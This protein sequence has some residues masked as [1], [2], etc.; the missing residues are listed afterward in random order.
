MKIGYKIALISTIGLLMANLV[1]AQEIPLLPSDKSVSQGQLPNGMKYF[2]VENPTVKGTADFALVNRTDNSV[3]RKSDIRISFSESVMDST[4][5]HLMN[6]ADEASPSDQA[7]I[8]SG[9]VKLASVAEKIKM[10]SY[11]TPVRDTAERAIY[12][13]KADDKIKVV[14]KENKERNLATIT[15]TWRSPRTDVKLMNTIQPAIS[16]LFTGQMGIIASDRLERCFRQAGIPATGISYR[17]TDSAMTPYDEQFSMTLSVAPEHLDQAVRI[18]S[19]VMASVDAGT[20]T[21]QEVKRAHTRF[22]ESI[23]A[24]SFRPIKSNREFVNR[25]ASAYL[26]NSSLASASQIH[27]FHASRQLPDDTELNLFNSI[28]SA[29]LDKTNN[30][31]IECVSSEAVDVNKVAE[32]FVAAWDRPSSMEWKDRVETEAFLKAANPEKKMKM[33]ASK[34]DPMSSGSVFTL[35]NGL[36]VLCR[37]QAADKRI[38]FSMALNGGYGNVQKLSAGEG[39]YFTDYLYTCRVA[40]VP[41][42]D[43]LAALAAKGVNMDLE[44]GVSSMSISGSASKYELVTVLQALTLMTSRLE[45]DDAA[46]DYYLKTVP[47]QIETLKGTRK[48]R[49]AAIESIMC[50]DNIWSDSKSNEP[51]QDF[52]KRAW[53]FYVDQFEKLDDGVLIVSG[54]I[55]EA[56]LKRQLATYGHQFKTLQ[57]A[58][59]RTSLRYQPISGVS[60]YTVKG[61]A[62]IID[63][64]MSAR[65]PLTSD[66]HVAAMAAAMVM[67][68]R[69]SDVFE[70]SGWSVELKEKFTNQ[71]DERFSV[72]V[73]LVRTDENGKKPMDAM[74]MLRATVSKMATEPL[75]KNQLSAYAAYLKNRMSLLCTDPSFW[76]EAV[77]GR[78]LHGKDIVTGY[79]A[80]CDALTSQKVLNIISSLD[81]S[82]KVEYITEK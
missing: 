53:N 33:S 74:S 51:G 1:P 41:M 7:I 37:P 67:R 58:S 73:T 68:Q 10:L 54:D 19:F 79:S 4:L 21:V 69:L 45:Q 61:N 6:L 26:F 32:T 66:N 29:V 38:Y 30:L 44:V 36:N 75:K 40:G 55:D 60:T 12:E 42:R 8:V 14:A 27:A 56:E 3:L 5:L 48:A 2:I 77:A 62:D 23:Y 71:P 64:A 25:A 35:E 59:S 76:T 63:Y 52:G 22:V 13:W 24:D 31:T 81:K 18:L 28:A 65:C 47:L 9:D 16:S 57:R 15:A 11:M 82:G 50:S 34:K 20:V 78:Q 70:G 39:A 46:L 80:K 17:H 72:M 43:F 49:V